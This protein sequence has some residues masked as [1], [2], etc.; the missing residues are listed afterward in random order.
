MPQHF[1]NLQSHYYTIIL[2]TF[3]REIYKPIG[4]NRQM[5]AFFPNR[6]LAHT[7]FLA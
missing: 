7:Y 3:R 5:D 1:L 4:E 6:N 2:L